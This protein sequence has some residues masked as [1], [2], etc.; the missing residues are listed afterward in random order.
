MIVCPKAFKYP[1]I[2]SMDVRI[3]LHPRENTH[4]FIRFPNRSITQRLH[5]VLMVDESKF[6]RPTTQ[7]NNKRP[8]KPDPV[9]L[10]VKK[11]AKLSLALYSPTESFPC[12]LVSPE[13]S[14]QK[15]CYTLHSFWSFGEQDNQLCA[16]ERFGSRNELRNFNT[17]IWAVRICLMLVSLLKSV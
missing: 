15:H 6:M 1:K 5:P 7:Y 9:Y 11:P 17:R 4:S 2:L 8:S 12:C 13:G 3:H 16:T 10:V 14:K